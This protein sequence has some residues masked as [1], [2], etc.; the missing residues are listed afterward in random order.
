MSPK[1]PPVTRALFALLLLAILVVALRPS[2]RAEHKSSD[3]EPKLTRDEIRLL[4]ESLANK[5]ERPSEGG[6]SPLVFS[7]DYDHNEDARIR[8]TIRRLER[9]SDPEDLWWCLRDHLHDDRYATPVTYDFYKHA[10]T[11]GNLCRERVADDLDAPFRNVIE[12]HFWRQFRVWYQLDEWCAAHNDV[13]LYQQQIERGEEIL[14]KLETLKQGDR[15]FWIPGDDDKPGI[16][17]DVGQQIE[18][19]KRTGMPIFSK[20][21]LIPSN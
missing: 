11:I 6:R 14:K 10:A 7:A 8:S 13:P 5:N 20:E 9:R 19:L 4:I 2:R 17:R 16:R 1:L 21:S 3:A 12:E 18:I 15:E